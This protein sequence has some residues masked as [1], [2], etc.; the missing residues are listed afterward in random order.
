MSNP[1]T[2]DFEAVLQ[3]S[4]GTINRLLATI[5]QNSLVAPNLPS[6]PHVAQIRI[7]DG[8]AVDGVRGAARVQ[9]A[10]PRVTLIHGVTDRFDLQVSVR[11][12]FIPD[13]GTNPLPAFIHGTVSARY[14]FEGIDPKCLGWSKHAA[15]YL[16]VRVIPDSVRFDGTADDDVKPNDTAVM[17]SVTGLPSA[18]A[19]NTAK[20][21][22]QIAWLLATRFE[23]S[24]HQVS[25]EFRRGSMRSLSIPLAGSAVSIPIGITGAPLGDVTSMQNVVLDGA[26][27]SIAVS[28]GYVMSVVNQ[29][30]GPIRSFN[31]T[32]PIHIDTGDFNPIPNINTVYR[33]TVGEPTAEWQPHDTFAIIK[34]KVSGSARTDSVLADATFDRGRHVLEQ[35][36]DLVAGPVARA[37]GP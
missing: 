17:A 11:A 33:V 6:F 35:S 15:D 27:M 30:L 25:P 23:A 31:K 1:L 19:A 7:G 36:V 24:P 37:A 13:S 28:V 4:G 32:I 34:I 9:I 16:W 26:D 10:V 29:A 5:H 18:D 22:K 14:H 3:V 21:T 8:H 2:G 20:V 12:W